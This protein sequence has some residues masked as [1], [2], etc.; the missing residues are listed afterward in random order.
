[1]Y[2]VA[3]FTQQTAVKLQ[4]SQTKGFLQYHVSQG[5][6]HIVWWPRIGLDQCYTH[7]RA[8]AE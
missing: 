8:Q 6:L 4:K 7:P 5:T 1:M 3:A 2:T